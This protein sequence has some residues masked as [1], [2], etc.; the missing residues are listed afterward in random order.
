[1]YSGIRSHDEGK[2]SRERT[3]GEERKKE[4][5]REREKAREK[6]RQNAENLNKSRA[7]S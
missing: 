5:K 3:K 6:A 7:A 1:L 2:V 4:R